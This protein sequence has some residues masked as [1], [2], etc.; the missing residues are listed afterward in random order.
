MRASSKNYRLKVPTT[1]L[2]AETCR[3]ARRDNTVGYETRLE[4]RFIFIPYWQ[5]E[6]RL[7]RFA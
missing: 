5:D 4:T 3:N 1:I 6:T 2:N 7:K